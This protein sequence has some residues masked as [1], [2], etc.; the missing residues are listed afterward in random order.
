MLYEHKTIGQ[1]IGHIRLAQN[2]SITF[3]STTV[4][5]PKSLASKSTYVKISSL[6]NQTDRIRSSS[7][8]LLKPTLNTVDPSS[9]NMHSSVHKPSSDALWHDTAL[10][11]L[12]LAR[13]VYIGCIGHVLLA[14]QQWFELVFA[15]ATELWETFVERAAVGTLWEVDALCRCTTL[16]LNV[17][18]NCNVRLETNLKR[19]IA[20]TKQKTT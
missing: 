10:I 6:Q 19:T 8:P 2:Y 18:E 16:R 17:L 12:F 13:M 11:A 1:I 15:R 3:L 4:C 14:L 7:Q 9:Y 20:R 5:L